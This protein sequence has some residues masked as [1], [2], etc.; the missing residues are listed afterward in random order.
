MR[1]SSL[2][3][4][5]TLRS[6]RAEAGGDWRACS[7]R[8]T[9]CASLLEMVHTNDSQHVQAAIR[10]SRLREVFSSFDWFEVETLADYVNGNEK[11]ARQEDEAA[12]CSRL[13]RHRRR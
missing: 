4:E 11:R 5:S 13:V 12:K 2:L 6:R 10:T 1:Y 3:A 7:C 8:H 9:V